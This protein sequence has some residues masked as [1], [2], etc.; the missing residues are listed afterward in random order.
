MIIATNKNGYKLTEFIQIDFVYVIYVFDEN[1][2]MLTKISFP[3]D[4]YNS[5]SKMELKLNETLNNYF[6]DCNELKDDIIKTINNS[7]KNQFKYG[8][9]NIEIRTVN[10]NTN[11]RNISDRLKEII[12]VNN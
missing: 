10:L 8:M 6:Q 7:S 3:P 4:I 11:W 1:N 2:K 9:H 12:G 5:G